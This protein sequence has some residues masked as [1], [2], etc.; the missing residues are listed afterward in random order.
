[1]YTYIHVVRIYISKT[2]FKSDYSN[3]KCLI[4]PV[5]DIISHFL[6]LVFRVDIIHLFLTS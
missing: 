2:P 3:S 5:F 6:L 1:M 4:V